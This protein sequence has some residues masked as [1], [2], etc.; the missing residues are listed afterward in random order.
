MWAADCS[1][2]FCSRQAATAW[3]ADLMPIMPV[4]GVEVSGSDTIQGSKVQQSRGD[5]VFAGQQSSCNRPRSHCLP[6]RQVQQPQQQA[7][8]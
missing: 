8:C 3:G 6:Q 4:R 7:M 5:V 1:R 2:V